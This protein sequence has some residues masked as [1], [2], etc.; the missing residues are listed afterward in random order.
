MCFLLFEKYRCFHILYPLFY[1][2]N[3]RADRKIP[4]PMLF[5]PF[6]GYRK[7]Y[8]VMIGNSALSN[9]K[10]AFGLV[11]LQSQFK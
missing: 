10:N 4:S 8:S 7:S 3:N 2:S 11:Q 6:L 5:L 1:K 9:K